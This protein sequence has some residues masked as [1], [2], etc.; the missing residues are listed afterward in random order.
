M[1]TI[2]IEKEN[3][4]AKNQISFDLDNIPQPT[5]EEESTSLP[6]EAFNQLDFEWVTNEVLLVVVKNKTGAKIGWFDSEICGRPL[7]DWVVMAGAGCENRI[8]KDNPNIIEVLKGIKTDK[9]YMLVL[10]SDTPLMTKEVICKVVDYFVK[11]RLN[12]MT[13]L[14]GYVFKVDFLQDID[15]YSSTVLEK[16]DSRA[17]MQVKDGQS[18]IFANNIIRDRIFDYHE[19]NGVTFAERNFT[20]IDADVEIDSGVV[21]KRCNVLKGECVIGKDTILQEGNVVVNSIIGEKCN[22]LGCRVYES[23]VAPGQK[24]ACQDFFGQRVFGK[25]D[26]D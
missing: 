20:V 1:E 10:Y 8:I 11:N 21:I 5:E 7:L 9:K 18:F 19:K 2:E 12:A 25:V 23:K 26:L 24:I 17:F 4:I 14:R 3:E 6:Q 15:T 13:L 22:L 16:F